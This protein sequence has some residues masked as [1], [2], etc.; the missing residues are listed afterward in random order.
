MDELVK[1]KKDQIQQR[2]KIAIKDKAFDTLQHLPLFIDWPLCLASL[3]SAIQCSEET[4]ARQSGFHFVSPG[5]APK[6]CLGMPST[7]TMTR[8][9]A[10]GLFLLE[11]SRGENCF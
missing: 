10:P 1:L 5:V 3:K 2:W 4:R 7:S 9:P 11:I 6:S 8:R